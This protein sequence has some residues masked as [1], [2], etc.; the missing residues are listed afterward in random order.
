MQLMNINIRL[1]GLNSGRYRKWEAD[2]HHENS[3]PAVFVFNGDV[4]QGLKAETLGK[5]DL[6]F[7]QEHLSILSGLYGLLKPLDGIQPYRLEMGTRLK[8]GKAEDLYEFW[9]NKYTISL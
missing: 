6:D 4:Y 3:W 7:A 2:H 8:T 9:G 1:A 5:E